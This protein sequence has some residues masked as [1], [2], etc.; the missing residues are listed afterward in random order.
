MTIH[1]NTI[2]KATIMILTIVIIFILALPVG[3]ASIYDFPQYMLDTINEGVINVIRDNLTYNG[4]ANTFY[5]YMVRGDTI[6]G[7]NV[8]SIV[9]NAVK[10][11]S[12]FIVVLLA[13]ARYFQNLEKGKEPMEGLY[14]IMSEIFLVGLFVMN[15]DIILEWLVDFGEW[16]IEIVLSLA[17]TP[18]ITTA[19]LKEVLGDDTGGAFWL[20]SSFFILA[21][22]WVLSLGTQ[23]VAQ[24]IAFSLLIEIGIR[25]AF[26]PFAVCEIYGEGLRS[27]GVR[28]L[29]RFLATFLK[30]AIA[31][32]TCFLG[33]VLLALSI[34]ALG[35]VDGINFSSIKLIFQFVF[36]VI[37]I[38]F[39]VIGVILKGGEY[40]NDIVG[41]GP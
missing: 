26:A 10:V 7:V 9:A 16:F 38:N 20:I 18:A 25:K 28:Y 36:R 3:H 34:E 21:I 4:G 2:I 31:L 23:I 37:A 30:I 11:V 14:E 41:V 5:G 13:F 8:I 39:T 40:A 35:G 27:P 1:K 6:G 33:D 15:I 22:P 32:L 29:K 24:W 19:T 17:D 12:G